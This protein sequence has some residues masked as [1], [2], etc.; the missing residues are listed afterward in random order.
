VKKNDYLTRAT[1][2]LP[3]IEWDSTEALTKAKRGVKEN[4]KTRSVLVR[5]GLQKQTVLKEG[6][7]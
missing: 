5:E 2:F 1:I 6:V 7:K 3:K 4:E